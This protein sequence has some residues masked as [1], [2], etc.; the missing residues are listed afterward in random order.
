MFS[1][2]TSDAVFL[3]TMPL[4]TAV[5]WCFTHSKVKTK[6]KKIH[7]RIFWKVLVLVIKIL[8]LFIEEYDCVV[9]Y[10]LT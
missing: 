10:N 6:K 4:V 2:V 5:F 8:T 7:S 3:F 9:K 1:T